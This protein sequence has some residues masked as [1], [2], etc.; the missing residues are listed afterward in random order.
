MSSPIVMA[1]GLQ[2][3]QGRH[4]VHHYLTGL[5]KIVIRPPKKGLKRLWKRFAINF[6]PLS[7]TVII[8]DLQVVLQ[9]FIPSLQETSMAITRCITQPLIQTVLRVLS[10]STQAYLL[11]VLLML[12]L[13][14]QEDSLQLQPYLPPQTTPLSLPPCFIYRRC[15]PQLLPLLQ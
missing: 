1:L 12:L 15:C 13:L 3:T 10:L 14:R 5:D 8:E 7:I 2:P 4:R 11:R 9:S 6:N